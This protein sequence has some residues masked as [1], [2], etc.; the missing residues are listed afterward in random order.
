MQ[1]GAKDGIRP[2]NMDLARLI[3]ER[4]ISY[5]AVLRCVSNPTEFK[6]Y[7]KKSM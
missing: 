2:M 4:Q 6:Q 7:L 1:I 3:N 5:D